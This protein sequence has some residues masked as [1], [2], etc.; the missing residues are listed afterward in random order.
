MIAQT[1]SPDEHEANAWATEFLIPPQ[2]MEHFVST[3]Q[4]TPHAVR[5]F[6]TSLEIA[7]GIVVGQLQKR[8][9]IKYSYL[10]ELKERFLWVDKK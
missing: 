1:D 3:G 4:F 2:D 6:A 10:N 5:R 8:G 7:P 9:A